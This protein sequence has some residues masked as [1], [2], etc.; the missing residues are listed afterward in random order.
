MVIIFIHIVE[1]GK[2]I[3]TPW[4]SVNWRP[5]VILRSLTIYG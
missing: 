5:L 1:I 3:F 2:K 4:S